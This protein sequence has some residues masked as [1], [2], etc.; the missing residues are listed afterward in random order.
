MVLPSI[1]IV[2][3][4]LRDVE[5]RITTIRMAAH[6]HLFSLT[7]LQRTEVAE[8]KLSTLEMTIS[9]T[10]VCVKIKMKRLLGILFISIISKFSNCS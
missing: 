6:Y 10:A 7:L 4:Q 1:Q 3:F 8:F 2:V 9:M 5:S